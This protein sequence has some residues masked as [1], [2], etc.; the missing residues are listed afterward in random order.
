[1]L[2]C[3]FC[4]LAQLVPCH[5]SWCIT[6][7]ITLSQLTPQ[8]PHS[9]ILWNSSP[10]IDGV[11]NSVPRTA[12]CEQAA[13]VV[14]GTTPS[15]ATGA[16]CGLPLSQ[17]SVASLCWRHSTVLACGHFGHQRCCSQPI[18]FSGAL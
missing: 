2:P 1:L 17:R 6:V 10:S 8:A 9:K 12:T 5:P 15:V 11:S 18:S 4:S 13:S 3:A 14:V 16:V 7:A